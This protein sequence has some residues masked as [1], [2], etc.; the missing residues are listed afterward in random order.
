MERTSAPKALGGEVLP[1]GTEPLQAD[2]P[3]VIGGHRL[4]GRLATGGA[5]VVYLAHDPAGE[6]VVVKTTRMRRADQ[7]QARRRLRTEAAAVRRLPGWCTP[8]LLI[9][10]SDEAPP[11]LVREY[12]EGPS[13]TQFVEGLG[14]LEPE[15]LRAL[16]EALARTLAAVHGAGLVHCDIE[17]ANVLLAADGPR[18]IDF[19]IAQERPLPGRPSEVGAVPYN[20]GW[21]AP[22]RLNGFAAG[23]ASDVF[24]WGC[25]LGYAATGHS[26]FDENAVAEGRWSATRAGELDEIEEPIRGLVEATLAVDPADRPGT[27]D[28]IARLSDPAESSAAGRRPGLAAPAGRAAVEEPTAPMRAIG[29]E[30][31]PAGHR[32]PGDPPPWPD[33]PAQTAPEP[34]SP[35]RPDRTDRPDRTPERAP[36]AFPAAEETA[37][38][39]EPVEH[40]AAAP[41][42]RRV[43]HSPR[44]SRTDPPE[45]RPRRLRA[46]ALVTA[47]AATLALIVTMVAVAVTDGN[48]HPRPAIPGSVV[49]PGQEQGTVGSQAPVTPRRWSYGPRPASAASSPDGTVPP[50]TGRRRHG[51][52]RPDAPSRP[53][54]AHPTS[55]P[56]T[57]SHTPAP[58]H[59]P[60]PSPT[61]TP[62]P[63]DTGPANG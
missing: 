37:R 35:V 50:L 36:A 6:H 40:A 61:P 22:E 55:R 19:T 27:A 24:G 12:I 10:A 44:T 29:P 28:L 21:V 31:G 62:T 60:T 53:G 26:P 2:D 3:A 34:V 1:P 13:L 58:T 25:L 9:D 7:A 32:E 11:Y 56:S 14:P 47:P 23:P 48:G 57:P 43:E 16:A 8:R 41:A 20:P 17:P 39:A 52:T 59:S 63:T 51:G 46:V 38:L 15:Q 30:A 45:Q 4:T 49:N 54:V 42:H 18:L 5:G 33:E